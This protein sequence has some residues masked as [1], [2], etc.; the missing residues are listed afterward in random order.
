MIIRN[1]DFS[2]MGQDNGAAEAKPDPEASAAVSNLVGTSVT[3]IKDIRFGFIRNSRAVIH[4]PD[5][6]HMI[7]FISQ[8]ADMAS[9]LR[10]LDGVIDQIDHDLYDQT[11]IHACQQE[12][13]ITFYGDTV[14]CA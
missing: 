2:S 1:G 5:P 14:F 11:G 3:H 7:L 6:Y 4:D 12:I 9:G 10:M 13:I 8:N